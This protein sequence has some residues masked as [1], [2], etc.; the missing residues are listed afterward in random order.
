MITK[1]LSFITFDSYGEEV[2]RTEKVRFLYSLPAFK[3]YT[4]RTG[5]NFFDDNK[6]AVDAYVNALLEIGLKTSDNLS[7]EDQIKLIPLLLQP[8]FMDFIVHAIPCLYGEVENGRLAQNQ[9]T[10]ENAE[11]APWFGDLL[12]VQFFTELIVELNK[13]RGTVPQDRKKPQ[14]K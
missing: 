14:Q 13:F 4:E 2:E 5:R 1:E 9:M 12:N 7:E 10:A 8:D 3:L 11:L 6:K